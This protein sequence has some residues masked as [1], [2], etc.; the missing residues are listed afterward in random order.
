M[1]KAIL[2]DSTKCTA[3]RGCQVACK[4]WNEHMAEQT[5]NRG[6]YENPEEL[7][8][9]TWV[10]IRFLETEHYGKFAWLFARRACM[11]CEDASCVMVCPTGS[12]VKT[13]EGFVHIDQDWCIGCGNCVQACPFGVPHKDHEGSGT[14]KKCTA[15]TSVGLNRQEEG[16]APA[17]VTTCPTGAL[18]FGDRDEMVNEGSQRVADLKAAGYS[19]AYLYGKNE[20]GGLHVMYVLDDSPEAYDLPASPQLASESLIGKWLTGIATAGVVAALPLWFIFKRRQQL[21]AEQSNAKGGE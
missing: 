11:H 12:I 10:K 5:E 14:A 9:E 18:K 4:S 3:C 6:S 13:D 8:P 15:C 1:S 20:L 17:C 16:L 19:N 7:S 2:Y 21:E